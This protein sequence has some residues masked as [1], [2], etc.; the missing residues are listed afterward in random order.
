[1]RRAESWL[2]L[3]LTVVGGDE[4]RSSLGKFAAEWSRGPL[5]PTAVIVAGHLRTGI[6]KEV[7]ENIRESIFQS[8]G[9]TDIYWILSDQGVAVPVVKAILEGWGFIRNVKIDVVDKDLYHSIETNCSHTLDVGV[10]LRDCRPARTPFLAIAAAFHRILQNEK[11]HHHRYSWIL[12]LRPDMVYKKRLPDLGSW[13]SKKKVAYLDGWHW[14]PCGNS[15]C[16]CVGDRFAIVHR[17]L[18]DSVFGVAT[19]YLH[20]RGCIGHCSYYTHLIPECALGTALLDAGLDPE[21]QI[22][23]L[24]SGDLLSC[25]PNTTS[26]QIMR[27]NS[28]SSNPDVV[29]SQRLP[30]TVPCDAPYWRPTGRRK[31]LGP[32]LKAQPLP[33]LKQ[34]P[35]EFWISSSDVL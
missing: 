27:R 10:S 26:P 3:L 6:F 20:H 19:S 7:Q 17:S 22:K 11:L 1:M 8:L 28:S 13:P 21:R 15:T 14:Q 9:G 25:G 5:S 16:F 35:V 34:R 31:H 2:L 4:P 24:F 32:S 18:A 30:D 33:P 23:K 29:V 12:R